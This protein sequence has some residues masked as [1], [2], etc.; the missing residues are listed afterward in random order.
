MKCNYCSDEAIKV[1]GK[2]VYPSRTDLYKLSFFICSP[3]DA[4][5]GCHIST[6]EPFG[7]LANKE[8]RKARQLAH[9]KFDLL[10]RGGLMSRKDAYI[11]L[12]TDLDLYENHIGHMDILDCIKVVEFSIEFMENVK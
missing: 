3:C 1:T 6:G 2:D 7:S 9:S 10:W 12:E 4:R 5:V 8:L 11:K